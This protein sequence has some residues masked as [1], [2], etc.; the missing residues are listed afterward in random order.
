MIIELL[1]ILFCLEIIQ[2]FLTA[3]KD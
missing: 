2:N 3:Y 1:E